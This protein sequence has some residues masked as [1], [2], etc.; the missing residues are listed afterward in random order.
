MNIPSDAW[1]VIGAI[2]AGMVA[3][4]V[5]FLV[6]ILAKEQKTSEFRQAWI[7]ALRQDLSDFASASISLTDSLRLLTGG[8]N[9]ADVVRDHLLKERYAE[10][11]QIEATRIRVLLRLNPVEH[12][13]LIGLID[14][15]YSYSAAREEKIYA[16]AGESLVSDFIKESQTVLKYEWKRVKRGETIFQITKWIALFSFVVSF[17]FAVAYWRGHFVVKYLA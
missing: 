6:T 5:S 9:S 1:Q 11:K 17:V 3:G 16:S 8:Q 10:V 12:T 7:D 15:A 14:R 4:L 2:F 13:K